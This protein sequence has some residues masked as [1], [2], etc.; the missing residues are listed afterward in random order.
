MSAINNAKLEASL[1]SAGN[2]AIN[3]NSANQFAHN[4]AH[5]YVT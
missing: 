1:W 2:T 4:Y 5:N 3:W